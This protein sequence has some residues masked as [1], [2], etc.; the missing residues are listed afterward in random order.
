MKKNILYFLGICAIAQIPATYTHT[1]QYYC[2]AADSGFYK[3]LLNLIGSIHR[4][5]F[6]ELAEIAVFDLGLTEEQRADLADIDKLTVHQVEKTNPAMFTLFQAHINQERHIRG[7]F[8]WKGPALKQA[9]EMFPYFLWIDAGTTVLQPIG[10]LFDYIQEKGY[11][12][13]TIGMEAELY[14][15]GWCTTKRI[16]DLFNVMSPELEWVLEKE[17]IMTGIMGMSRTVQ[18]SCIMPLYELSKDIRNFADDGTSFNGPACGRH[19]QTILGLLVY[20]QGLTYF[21]QDQTQKI[22]MLLKVNGTQEPLY[23]TWED[24]Y[25]QN[26]THIYS[27]RKNLSTMVCTLPEIRIKKRK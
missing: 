23:I 19:D 9:L 3:Q 5:N 8:S 26:K 11:F 1:P 20:L 22:P 10:H 14:N 13:S 16:R 17:Q 4:V 12:F 25:I 2:T 24:K 27:S 15:M 18:N 21:E 6:N 7:W